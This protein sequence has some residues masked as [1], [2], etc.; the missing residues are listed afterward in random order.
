MGYTIIPRNRRRVAV[1][2]GDGF[3]GSGEQE[4]KAGLNLEEMIF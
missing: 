1:T 4:C 2:V 3:C